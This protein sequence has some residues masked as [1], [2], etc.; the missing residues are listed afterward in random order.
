MTIKH[1]VEYYES[2]RGWGCDIWETPY[3]TK[4]EALRMVKECNDK[5]MGQQTTPDY[6]IKASY[7]GETFVNEEKK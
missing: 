3:D 7:L 5:F 6:Y 1:V 2:E 4:E